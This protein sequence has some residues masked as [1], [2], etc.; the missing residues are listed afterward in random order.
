[1]SKSLV[2]DTNIVIYA[3]QGSPH[4]TSLLNNQKLIISFVT[5]IELLSLPK[6]TAQDERLIQEFIEACSLADYS[7]LLKQKVIEFRKRYKLKMADAF[8]AVT[9]VLL[10][11]PLASSDSVFGKL[12]ELNFIKIDV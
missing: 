10:D 3:L 5:E 6:A 9:A 4:I 11:I 12:T 7:S 8:V 1:M 2:V